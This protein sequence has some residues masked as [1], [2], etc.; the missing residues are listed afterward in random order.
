MGINYLVAAALTQ[1]LP[2]VPRGSG[3]ASADLKGRVP[4]ESLL[5][6]WRTEIRSYLASGGRAH[7]FKG[8]RVISDHAKFLQCTLNALARAVLSPDCILEAL[9]TFQTY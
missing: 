1:I 4:E 3:L 5:T 9:E 6:A 8:A 2:G 7:E